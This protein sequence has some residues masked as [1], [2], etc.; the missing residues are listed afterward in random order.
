MPHGSD[1]SPLLITSQPEVCFPCH[2]R[3]HFDDRSAGYRNHPVRPIYYDVNRDASLTC[4]SS[5]HEPHGTPNNYMLRYYDFPL[6]G[7]CL[8]C[9]AAVPGVVV[10]EDY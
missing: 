9:H 7:N 3:V 4:T 5:C 1:S 8:F 10:G 6:D 2:E